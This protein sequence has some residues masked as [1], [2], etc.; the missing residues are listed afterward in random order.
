ML[1]KTKDIIGRTTLKNVGTAKIDIVINRQTRTLSP[2][3]SITIDKGQKYT[4]KVR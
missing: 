2:G 3:E 4:A 1:T